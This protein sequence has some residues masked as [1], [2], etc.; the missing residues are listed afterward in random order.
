M[1]K[2]ADAFEMWPKVASNDIRDDGKLEL[3]AGHKGSK[4]FER[5]DDIGLVLRA[6]GAAD[7]SAMLE[8][9]V[10]DVRANEARHA[11]DEDLALKSSHGVPSFG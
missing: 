2:E 7:V 10:C 1:D 11:E 6:D 8:E 4:H 9:G 5:S 3:A